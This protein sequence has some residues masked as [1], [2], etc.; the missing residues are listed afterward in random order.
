MG[1]EGA[2]R[3]TFGED[4]VDH[5]KGCVCV[6]VELIGRSLLK[7]CTARNPHTQEIEA[8]LKSAFSQIT[9]LFLFGCA[10]VK[11]AEPRTSSHRERTVLCMHSPAIAYPVHTHPLL[12]TPVSLES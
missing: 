4:V 1:A 2:G 7:S 8:S 12:Y 6:E 9:M 10:A 11:T 3:G 5:P